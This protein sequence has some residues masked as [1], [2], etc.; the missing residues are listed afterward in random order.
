M[1]FVGWLC[2][3]MAIIVMVSTV[4]IFTTGLVVDAYL[5]SI[6]A[7]FNIQ[8]EGQPFA[9][10]SA[11][12]G[13]MGKKDSPVI[14]DTD[15]K[16]QVTQDDKEP[17][18]ESSSI[19]KDTEPATKTDTTEDNGSSSES[20]KEEAPDDALSVM[21]QSITEATGVE[22]QDQQVIVSPDDVARKRDDLPASEKEEIFNILMTKLPQ[23]QLQEITVAME[24][25]LT[26]Q[27]LKRVEEIIS[28]YLSEEEYAK[29]MTL[30]K[31]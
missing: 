20:G 7:S 26:E 12:Q 4:T 2:K 24:D 27:E 28:K 15:S 16:A 10:G 23:D 13:I 19:A 9:W 30:L 25:G 8:L 3:M 14:E 17:V 18:S 11:L 21:G 31:S 5:K 22:Q 1:K 29:L 6:L